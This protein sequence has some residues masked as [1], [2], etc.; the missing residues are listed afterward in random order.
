MR[1]SIAVA[2]ITAGLLFASSLPVAAQTIVLVSVRTPGDVPVPGARVDFVPRTSDAPAKP[3]A[4]A[5]TD[6]NGQAVLAVPSGHYEVIVSAPGFERVSTA[7]TL[8]GID[9]TLS[10]MIIDAPDGEP[11]R[12]PTRG[13]AAVVRG[14]LLTLAGDPVLGAAVHL[15]A[16]GRPDGSSTTWEADGTF[17]TV[18]AVGLFQTAVLTIEPSNLPIK[19]MPAV[20]FVPDAEEYSLRVP[21]SPDGET[22]VGDIRVSAH[23]QLRLLVTLGDGSGRVPQDASVWV[24]RPRTSRTY[25]DR[26]NRT[27]IKYGPR[28]SGSWRE[29][30]G[31]F[32]VGPLPPGP[33]TVYAV[34]DRS[35]PTLAAMAKVDVQAH[36]ANEIHL[37]LL[38]GARIT[39]R[40]EFA[41]RT[42]PLQGSGPLR[43][44]AAT[45]DHG[46]GS[47]YGLV[48]D[49]GS[50]RITGLV[51]V[52]C[53]RVYGLPP[54]A[55][56]S[57]IEHAGRE[58]TNVPLNLELGQEISVNIFVVPGTPDS[59][60][61]K[62][63]AD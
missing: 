21:I 63:H 16:N 51:G 31:T 49:D 42:A 55:R 48:A 22:D 52:R 33:V 34:N 6:V 27:V 50:F 3:V 11:A 15:S 38:Q 32:R 61:P 35:K 59:A 25:R 28:G 12:R 1:R 60:P 44:L 14:R 10:F 9:A 30:D 53:L 24:D 41:G 23:A 54:G 47:D 18:A 37:E 13:S 43:V 17:R 36:A 8:T 56:V 40:V 7:A 58:I 62:C 2:L 4:S 19:D 45:S 5:S 39:G 26:D 57:A 46:F 29:P 20:I